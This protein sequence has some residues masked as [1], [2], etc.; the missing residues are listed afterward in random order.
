MSYPCFELPLPDGTVQRICIYFAIPQRWW[1]D[2]DPGPLRRIFG[3][4]VHFGQE[5][6][7]PTPSPWKDL[8]LVAT[9]DAM[10]QAASGKEMKETLQRAFADASQLVEADLSARVGKLDAADLEAVFAK[11]K[12]R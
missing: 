12:V 5:V 2:P 4:E 8:A 9:L 3:E 6:Q 10:V 11:G 7:G 1:D